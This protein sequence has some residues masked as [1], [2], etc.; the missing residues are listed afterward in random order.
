MFIYVFVIYINIE[1][2]M[3]GQLTTSRPNVGFPLMYETC[4]WGETHMSK[5]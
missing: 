2:N 1:L 5:S 3:A 4:I